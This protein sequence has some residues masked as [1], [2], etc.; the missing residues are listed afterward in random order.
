MVMSF[1][2]RRQGDWTET[3]MSLALQL[4][5]YRLTT[6]EILY[7]L[8]DH[9]EIL[10]SYIWQDLDLA[11]G[12]PVLQKFL[13]FWHREL[14]GKV[15]LGARGLS[16]P[17]QAAVVSEPRQP[18]CACTEQGRCFAEI[19]TS[20]AGRYAYIAGHALRRSRIS[21]NSAGGPCS[22]PQPPASRGLAIRRRR[23]GPSDD[24]PGRRH[25][26]DRLWPVDHGMGTARRHASADE[27]GGMA[28][29]IP[30]LPA[31]P[32]IPSGE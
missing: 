31:D 15:A 2:C 20:G 14:D 10:Q 21:W 8:P 28:T 26:P 12:F 7:R 30:P 32:A 13:D 19:F 3:I 5:D 24:R 6:A 29:Y 23:H 17:D 11:P 1:C 16:Q 25:P 27:R 22:T 4:N 9:P 18:T